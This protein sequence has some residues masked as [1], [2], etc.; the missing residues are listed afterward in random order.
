MNR[1]SPRV[2]QLS[3][4]AAAS[5][6]I[7]VVLLFVA[8]SAAAQTPPAPGAPSGNLAD[9]NTFG[10]TWQKF[11]TG[12]LQPMLN[13]ILS[14]AGGGLNYVTWASIMVGAGFTITVL[15]SL[16]KWVFGAASGV[17][18][19]T[20]FARGVIISGLYVT[21]SS[22]TSLFFNA[23]Y[24][25][26]FLIQQQALGD[27]TT[28]GPAVF[29]AKAMSSIGF[30]TGSFFSLTLSAVIYGT[31]FFVFEA[32]LIV[33]SFFVAAWPTL[34]YAIATIV[35]PIM[36]PFLFIEQLSGFFDGWIKLF[37]TGL[38][39]LIISRVVLIVIALL[40]GSFF[41]VGYS[42]SPDIVPMLVNTTSLANVIILFVLT[43][44]S[45]FLLFF[46]GSLVATIVGGS[47]LGLSNAIGRGALLAARL[48]A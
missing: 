30:G 18:V 37:F 26:S 17:D 13:A 40:F 38:F 23:A 5:A 33:M 22:W 15:I 36:F 12:Q 28:M 29:I 2:G 32:L 27:S 31:F 14:G 4:A 35:G 20:V 1:S 43:G 19:V 47:N 9:F 39:F 41:S 34:L 11:I 45:L 44:T 25:L 48:A 16:Y 42:T 3:A 6:G 8:A 21:Y 46:T 10:S 24:E 7:A